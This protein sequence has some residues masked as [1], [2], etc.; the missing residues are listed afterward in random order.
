MVQIRLRKTVTNSTVCPLF[1]SLGLGLAPGV[2]DASAQIPSRQG[3]F[4]ACVRLDKDQD[5]GRLAR[6]G[7][8]DE[9]CKKNE[10]RVQWSVTGPQ[11][12]PGPQGPVGPQG[13][14]GPTGP[15]G[16][17]GPT[18]A[19]GPAGAEGAR[20]ASVA[21]EEIGIGAAQCSGLGGVK[22]TLVD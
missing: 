11:G 7:A 20:G 15:A 17:P 9:A 22:L 13:A 21:L 8:A 16:P 12:P 1:L 4:F 14:I 19:T 10:V 6:L 2:L 5:E 3:V 18:G